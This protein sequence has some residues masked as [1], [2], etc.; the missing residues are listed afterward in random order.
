VE[1]KKRRTPSPICKCLRDWNISAIFL[2][3]AYIFL[4][5]LSIVSSVIVASKF[6]SLDPIWVEI[7]AMTAA[8]SVGLLSALDIGGNA[9]RMRKAWRKLNAAV[10][11][12]EEEENY[13]IEELL[14]TYEAAE[15]MIADSKE[16]AK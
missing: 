1:E 10:I 16:S 2:R 13:T 12:Y 15:A 4:V 11:K 8:I 5:L 6:S 14:S 7:L 3:V 9:N